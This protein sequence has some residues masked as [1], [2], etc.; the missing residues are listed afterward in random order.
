[1]RLINVKTRDLEQH[2]GCDIQHYAILSH[3]WEDQE[4]PFYDWQHSRDEIKD[5]KGFLKIIHACEQAERDNLDYLWC[6]TNCIDK[7]SS[8]ELSG[9]Q[10]DVFLVSRLSNLLCLFK[11]RAPALSVGFRRVT[12]IWPGSFSGLERYQWG[13]GFCFPP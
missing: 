10:L 7:T 6:D 8:A 4:V 11:R 13:G 9:D 2:Y 1:M 3:R 5:K 12:T